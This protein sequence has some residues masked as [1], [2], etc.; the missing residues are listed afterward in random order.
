M[1]KR[2]KPIPKFADEAAERAF[3][4]SLD[5]DSSEYFDSS[6]STQAQFPNL[7]TSTTSIS[8]RLPDALLAHIKTMANKLDVPYQSLMKLWLAEKLD[9]AERPTRS[10]RRRVAR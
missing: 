1:S 9:E 4:E 5:N 10:V 2:I 8:L 7:K 6:K 3:W